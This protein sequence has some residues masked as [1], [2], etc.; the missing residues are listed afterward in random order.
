VCPGAIAVQ[1][2]GVRR[3]RRVGRASEEIMCVCWRGANAG[4]YSGLR[5]K[6]YTTGWVCGWVE[7]DG[8]GDGVVL[9]WK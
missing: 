5:W 1:T 7:P 2:E 3:G 6:C 4:A 8:D 9:F